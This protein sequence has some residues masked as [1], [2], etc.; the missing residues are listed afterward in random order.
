MA[1]VVLDV[2]GVVV[3]RPKVFSVRWSEKNNVPIEKIL[4]FIKGDFQ[5]CLVG[6]GDLKEVLPKWL[7]YWG[8]NED[9][10]KVMEFWFSGEAEV[11]TEMMEEIEELRRHG[12]KCYLATNNEKYRV[13]YLRDKVGLASKVDGILSSADL[14][15]KKPHREFFTKL[16]SMIGVSNPNEIWFWDDDEENVAGAQKAGWRARLFVGVEGFSKEVKLV[17]GRD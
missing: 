8:T 2:D 17:D 13:E 11:N 12:I 3:A 15:A 5:R 7:K 9:V 4:E 1:V 16:Q 10:E 14:G 6:Q